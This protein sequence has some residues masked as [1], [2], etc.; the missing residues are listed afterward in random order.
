MEEPNIPEIILKE[1]INDKIIKEEEMLIDPLGETLIETKAEPKI[2]KEVIYD[3]EKNIFVNYA[4]E[5]QQFACEF[6]EQNFSTKQL[7]NCHIKENHNKFACEKC[8][9]IFNF[10]HSLNYHVKSIHQELKYECKHCD[11]AFKTE[12]G[13]DDHSKSMHQVMRIFRPKT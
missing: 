13:L 11:A 1:D 3:S 8:E 6:C 2:T 9:N 12:Q 7:L 10:P 4:T 5:K